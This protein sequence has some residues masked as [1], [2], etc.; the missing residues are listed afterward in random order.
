MAVELVFNFYDGA[1]PARVEALEARVT[2]FGEQLD[3]ANAQA[4]EYNEDVTAKLAQQQTQIDAVQAEIDA[5]EATV[6]DVSALQAKFD[7]LKGTLD[8]G[9][10]AVGDADGDGNPAPVTPAP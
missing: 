1:D 5:L 8:A 7:T 9:T 3:A 10:A 6:G 2:S 4:A